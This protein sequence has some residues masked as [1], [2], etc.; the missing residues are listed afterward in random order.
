MTN[1]LIQDDLA[2]GTITNEDAA[3][4]LSIDDL[5]V[6]E[7]SG[8]PATA[9]FTVT[10]TGATEVEAL[11]DWAT[12]DGTAIAGSDYTADG[13]TLSFGPAQTSRTFQVT[14]TGDV[15]DEPAETFSAALS[16]PA[17]ATVA[18][19]TGTA[20]IIDDDKAPTTLTLKVG[21]GPSTV[22]A[23][24]LLEPAVSGMKVK[25][26][27]LRK[28]NGAFKRVGRKTVMVKN[29]MD[30]DGDG[31]NEGRYLANFAK[32][33][34]GTYKFVVKYAGNANYKSATKSKI[35]TI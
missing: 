5:S 26:T 24:G 18:D 16:N 10:K 30:R 32:G 25:I 19:A 8:S 34:K 15:V 17:D 23:K 6:T 33:P 35:F 2:S 21:R 31:L 9:T 11:I 29:L 14:V 27:L 20:T 22:R 13:G 3:P 28:V 1:G 4:T 7:T 12:A